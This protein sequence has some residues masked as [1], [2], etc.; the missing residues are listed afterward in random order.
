M[1]RPLPQ[2]NPVMR[3]RLKTSDDSPLANLRPVRATPLASSG[4]NCFFSPVQCRLPVSQMKSMDNSR[5]RLFTND[6]PPMGPFD[7]IRRFRDY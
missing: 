7:R 6:Q 2:L 3:Y 5:R 1:F 4:R